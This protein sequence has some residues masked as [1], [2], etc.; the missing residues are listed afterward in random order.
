MYTPVRPSRAASKAIAK[1]REAMC[2][3]RN[4]YFFTLLIF[5][6]EESLLPNLSRPGI[7]LVEAFVGDESW[8]YSGTI[9]VRITFVIRDFLEH[10]TNRMVQKIVVVVVQNRICYPSGNAFNRSVGRELGSREI[11]NI[12]SLKVP[13]SGQ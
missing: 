9:T 10:W 8:I 13:A 11:G 3:A 1:T 2:E 5:P 12:N 7:L 6:S 4:P